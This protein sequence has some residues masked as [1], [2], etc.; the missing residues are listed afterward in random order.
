MKNK[1]QHI[2]VFTGASGV[3]KSTCM[4]YLSE[5]Y[6]IDCIELSARPFYKIMDNLMMS[7]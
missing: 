3:G 1:K 5:N 7:K 2:F 4:K 6:G